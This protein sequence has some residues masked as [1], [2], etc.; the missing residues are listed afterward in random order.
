MVHVIPLSVGQRRRDAGNPVQ[1]A[2]SPPP[3]E[4]VQPLDDE[5]QALAGHYQLR[6]AQ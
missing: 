5:W 3:G 1:G 4:A 6:Q 2:D